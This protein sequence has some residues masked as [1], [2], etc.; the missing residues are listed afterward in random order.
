MESRASEVVV[1]YEV[2]EV[3]VQI[4]QGLV[5]HCKDSHFYS[6]MKPFRGLSR[7]ETQFDISFNKVSVNWEYFQGKLSEFIQVEESSLCQVL[8]ERQN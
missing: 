5:G 7:E 8:C 4:T 2:C 3:G 6:E 1:G